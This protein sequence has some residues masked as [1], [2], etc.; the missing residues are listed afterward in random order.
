M[1]NK[2]RKLQPIDAGELLSDMDNNDFPPELFHHIVSYI[3]AYPYYITLSRVSRQW[4]NELETEIIVRDLF[5][6]NAKAKR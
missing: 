4:Q 3:P 2:R 1:Q 5:L 6:T